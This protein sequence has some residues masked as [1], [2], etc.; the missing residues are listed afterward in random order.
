ML[1]IGTKNFA[2]QSVLTNGLVN[3]GAVY[4]RYCKKSCGVKT[5]DFSGS[6]ISL[7][8]S[9]IY[10]VTITA[11]ISAPT[12]GDVTLTLFENGVAIPGALATE[13]ITTATTEFRTI[14]IDYFI[15]VDNDYVLNTPTTLA[16]S[17]TLV[18][19]GIPSTINN[20][21]ANVV[22]VL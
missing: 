20:V 2:P 1:L 13:T 15:L 7:Q 12:A 5:F 6:A 3:L 8:K 14:T 22:K 21:V 9:G 19:T 18:N 16:K 17:L 11:I 10:Q 4:R